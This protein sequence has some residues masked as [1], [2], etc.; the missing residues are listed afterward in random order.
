MVGYGA[1]SFGELDEEVNRGISVNNNQYC[2]R[3]FIP[4]PYSKMDWGSGGG[5]R[6][7]SQQGKRMYIPRVVNH[8]EISGTVEETERGKQLVLWVS[9]SSEKAQMKTIHASIARLHSLS[10]PARPPAP[11]PGVTYQTPPCPPLT[12]GH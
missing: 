3:T 7:S 1:S 9:D 8:K 2:G 12:K 11:H 6:G 4:I 5:G 10:L